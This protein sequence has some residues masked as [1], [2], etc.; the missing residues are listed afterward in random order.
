M[1]FALV[2]VACKFVFPFADEKKP[3][4]FTNMGNPICRGAEIDI[5]IITTLPIS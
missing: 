5:A 2:T 4:T 3:A 1:Y